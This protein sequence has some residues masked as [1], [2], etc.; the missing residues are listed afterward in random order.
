MKEL[1]ERLLESVDKLPA[2]EGKV[3]T[4][5]RLNAARAVRAE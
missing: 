5:G 3:A 4:G 1:R 2:L